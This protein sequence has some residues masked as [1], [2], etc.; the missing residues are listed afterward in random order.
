MNQAIKNAEGHFWQ[1]LKRELI[2]SFTRF[3]LSIT[4]AFLAPERCLPASFLERTKAQMENPPSAPQLSLK[5][6]ELRYP[7][8]L[9]PLCFC[10]K[11]LEI[12]LYAGPAKPPIGM[13]KVLAI[14]RNNIRI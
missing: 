6:A 12:T 9:K 14:L 1:R 5:P 8:M 3:L 13:L 4:D 11:S 7:L 10:S 2:N